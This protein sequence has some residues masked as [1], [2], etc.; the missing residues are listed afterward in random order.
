M[1]RLFYPRH[2]TSRTPFVA[3]NRSV[4]RTLTLTALPPHYSTGSTISSDIGAHMAP[5]TT[6]LA[7]GKDWVPRTNPSTI[8]RLRDVM[9]ATLNCTQVNKYMLLTRGL[10]G[11]RWTPEELFGHSL[12]DMLRPEWPL[13][14]PTPPPATPAA[15]AEGALPPPLAAFKGPT[16][17]VA[18]IMAALP[19]PVAPPEGYTSPRATAE[20]AL[21]TPA[22]Q[23]VNPTAPT[24]VSATAL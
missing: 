7:L 2:G 19:P 15:V 8:L 18:V 3:R 12:S 5:F 17:P 6:S 9:M 23:P 10:L 4:I 16:A 20:V 21:P 24:A 11:H 22:A 14:P 1:N 13:Q